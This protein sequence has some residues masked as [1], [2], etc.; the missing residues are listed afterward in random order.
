MRRDR[1]FKRAQMPK[2][3]RVRACK[4]EQKA[5]SWRATCALDQS[6]NADRATYQQRMASYFAAREEKPTAEQL[7]EM[8]WGFVCFALCCVA[9]RLV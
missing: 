7:G 4:A 5:R 3:T 6:A 2:S 9:A 8:L 1:W